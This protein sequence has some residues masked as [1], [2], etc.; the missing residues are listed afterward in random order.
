MCIMLRYKFFNLAPSATVGHDGAG[1]NKEAKNKFN[2][3]DFNSD[4]RG[5]DCDIVFSKQSIGN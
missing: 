4:F 3:W 2:L 5:V 1:K